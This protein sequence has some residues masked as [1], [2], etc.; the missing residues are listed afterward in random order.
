M[1]N[2]NYED[3]A[4]SAVSGVRGLDSNIIKDD[5]GKRTETNKKID[6]YIFTLISHSQPADELLV[7]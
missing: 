3:Y 7:K 6:T 5:E 4:P 1:R 2:G